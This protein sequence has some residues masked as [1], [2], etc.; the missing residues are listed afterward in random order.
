MKGTTMR[1]RFLLTAVVV[2]AYGRAHANELGQPLS[3]ADW[4]IARPG[5]WCETIKPYPANGKATIAA[6]DAVDNEGHLLYVK[7]TTTTSEC[8]APYGNGQPYFL[9]RLELWQGLASGDELVAFFQERCVVP[10]TSV[11]F[12]IDL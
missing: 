9:R 5:F 11:D 7:E 1:Q 2:L 3:C 12:N 10:G 6:G 4:V 8:G